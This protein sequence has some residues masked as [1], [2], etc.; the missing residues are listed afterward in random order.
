MSMKSRLIIVIAFF[1]SILAAGIGMLGTLAAAL[2][3]GFLIC[4]IY[5]EWGGEPN[6]TIG[7]PRR[8][9]SDRGGRPRDL[10]PGLPSSIYRTR[11]LNMR[12]LEPI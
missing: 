6:E 3:G 4:R 5:R 1:V 7:E 8:W 12:V 9:Q 10:L 2:F 11:R